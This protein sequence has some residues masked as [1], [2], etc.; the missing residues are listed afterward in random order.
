M[1]QAIQVFFTVILKRERGFTSR[2]FVISNQ[3]GVFGQLRVFFVFPVA[4]KI[5]LLAKV[6]LRGSDFCE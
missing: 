6:V 4:G 3:Y 5:V 1:M 2:S